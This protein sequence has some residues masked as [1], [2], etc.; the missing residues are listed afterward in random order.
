MVRTDCELYGGLIRGSYN[1]TGAAAAANNV[2]AWGP[3][4]VAAANTSRGDNNALL[5]RIYQPKWPVTK[6][7]TSNEHKLIETNN[8][9]VVVGFN[10]DIL[11][12]NIKKNMTWIIENVIFGIPVPD[13]N[14]NNIAT[15][16]CNLYRQFDDFEGKDVKLCKNKYIYTENLSTINT[17]GTTYP[18]SRNMPIKCFPTA[19]A[20]DE[21]TI[22]NDGNNGIISFI[23]GTECRLTYT[24]SATADMS[25]E[26]NIGTKYTPGAV[27]R[28]PVYP[29]DNK[30]VSTKIA[31]A[32]R[33]TWTCFNF[34]MTSTEFL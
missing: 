9:N 17:T 12:L 3:Q 1:A 33:S 32:P 14:I 18:V 22:Q 28:N 15:I 2:I 30:A 25:F 26:I 8:K 10:E 24:R 20:G 23:E 19:G 29:A 6:I 13:T 21:V 4:A 7:A 34:D 11:P 27:L 31:D 5:H 16:I